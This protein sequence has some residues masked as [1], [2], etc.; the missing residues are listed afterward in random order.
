MS[1]VLLVR[2]LRQ[3]KNNTK[4]SEDIV[5]LSECHK[6]MH[7]LQAT[8]ILWLTAVLHYSTDVLLLINLKPGS[9]KTRVKGKLSF[10]KKNFEINN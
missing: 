10:R 6:E 5:F 3:K 1:D 2:L 9:I 8:V 7:L 4:T